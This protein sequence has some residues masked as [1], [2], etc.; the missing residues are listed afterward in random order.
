[1]KDNLASQTA[2]TVLQGVVHTG[3]QDR[4]KALVSEE[5][6]SAC[7]RILN[8]SEEGRKR[9]RQLGNPMVSAGL[10]ALQRLLLPGIAIHYVTRKLAIE[11]YVKSS[12]ENGTT[13]VVN[14]GAGFD[15]LMYELSRAHPDLT[16]SNWTT[17]RPQNKSAWP[18]MRTDR[19][20]CICIRWICLRCHLE[21]PWVMFPPLTPPRH[22]FHL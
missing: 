3:R 4:T 17:R 11:G 22:L 12:I 7:L 15:T 2:Y 6:M 14:I 20:T 21:T 10:K 1:M 16:L 19:A 8:S 9:L 18:L 13:Q 5:K